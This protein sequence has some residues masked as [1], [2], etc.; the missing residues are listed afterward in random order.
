MRLGLSFG[1]L[2]AVFAFATVVRAEGDKV[3]VDLKSGPIAPRLQMAEDARGVYKVRLVGQVENTGAGALSLEL[4]LTTRKYNE[5]GYQEFV[6]DESPLRLDVTLRFVKKGTVTVPSGPRLGAAEVE[7]E[8]SRYEIHGPKLLTKLSLAIPTADGWK[9]GRLLVHDKEGKVRDVIDFLRPPEPREIPPPPPCH[10]GCFPAGTKI[11]VADGTCLV[12]KVAVGDKITTIG[13]DGKSSSAKVTSIYVVDNRLWTV[14][15]DAGDLVTTETQP[16]ALADGK[17]RAAGELKAGDKI[18]RWD[19]KERKTATIAS[20][21][22]TERMEKVYN[23][24][25]GETTLFVAND[26]I[27]RSKPPAVVVP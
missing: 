22:A 5:F 2:L 1:A 10:P 7:V 20:V 3:A 9:A 13:A 23:L 19:G 6:P 4:D 21:K 26:F 27:A 11:R 24:V 8:W 25:L 12:E 18:Y 16:L 15:T 17:L 14:K